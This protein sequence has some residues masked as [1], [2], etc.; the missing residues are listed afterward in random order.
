MA[1]WPQAVYDEYPE[2]P[3]EAKGF[4]IAH[5]KGPI[6]C[7][8]CGETK[9]RAH[10]HRV[11]Y[12][13][14]H[15]SRY[16]NLYTTLC[17]VCKTKQ[18]V[19]KAKE[20]AVER[21]V[22]KATRAE[23][24]KLVKKAAA[25]RATM[26]HVKAA[27][28]KRERNK[29]KARAEDL[30]K[31]ETEAQRELASR[32]LAKVDLL[33]YIERFNPNYLAGWVH[34][35]I[36]RRLRK[37]VEDVENKKSPRLILNVPP[38]HGKSMIASENFP[39]WLLGKHPDWE[40][41]ATSYSLDLP[42]QFSR[43]VRERIRDS[44]YRTLFP[45]TALS[46]DSQAAEMWRTTANGGYR[47]SGVGGGI[48]GM[49]AH[50]VPLTEEVLT[51]EGYKTLGSLIKDGSEAPNVVS[52]ELGQ[53]VERPIDGIITRRSD[54]YYVVTTERGEFK[55]TGEHPVCVGFV[56]GKPQYRRVDDLRV[57]ESLAAFDVPFASGEETGCGVPSLWNTVLKV[58]EQVSWGRERLRNTVSRVLERL[59]GGA[60][61]AAVYRGTD[62]PHL[63]RGVSACQE[64]HKG[65]AG[66]W[67][68]ASLL[69]QQVLRGVS[70]QDLC[71]GAAPPLQ[72]CGDGVLSLRGAVSAQEEPLNCG[73][74]QDPLLQPGVLLQRLG[75]SPYPEGQSYP[76]ATFLPSRVQ[77][78]QGAAAGCQATL[79]RVR[80]DR[81]R[82]TPSGQRQ[83]EQLAGELSPRVPVLPHAASPSSD[84][85]YT[86][87]VACRRVH[88]ELEVGDLC[89]EKAHNYLLRHG[90]LSSNCLIIDDP[91]KDQNEADSETIRQSTW[92]WYTTTAYTRLAPGGGVLVIQ[93]RW[94]DGDLS[95]RI[96][97]AHH[98]F[99]REVDRLTSEIQH[100]KFSGQQAYAKEMIDE[101]AELRASNDTWEIIKYPAIA[102][103]DEVLTQSGHIVPVTS[104]ERRPH[105]RVLRAKGDPLHAD[106]FHL[107]MLKKIKKTLQP[108]HWSALYQQNPIP[109]EGLFFTKD[110]I[111]FEPVIPDYREMYTFAAWDLAVG[112]K[113]MNDYT[114]GIVGALD[115]MDNIHIIDMIRMRSN[116]HYTAEAI[117]DTAQKY[118]CQLNGIEKGVLELALRPQLEKRMRERRFYPPFAEGDLALKPITDKIVRARPLQGRMQ[119]GKV[120]FPAN[121]PWVETVLHELLRF[122][123][124]VHDDIVDA[125]A[126]LARLVMSQAAPKEPRHNRG[127]DSYSN[128]ESWKRR[129]DLIAGA[130][131]KTWMSS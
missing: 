75:W 111:R 94:H 2:Y 17:L 127:Y 123:G 43:K 9:P 25:T 82:A 48:T 108:R 45:K 27:Q 36:C 101:L 120:I 10:M 24:K 56:E 38:R 105:G 61:D 103:H 78:H 125:L 109:D 62:V 59:F 91:V 49:G 89:V 39:S 21:E 117:L 130:G 70:G 7:E 23:R 107:N 65:Q 57:G 11:T 40:I 68:R 74:H 69:L 1:K 64:P 3:D 19:D 88:A 66:P 131:Q 16:K 12:P 15:E 106:R 113:N 84:A 80:R 18:A 28:E 100:A 32:A 98:E 42:L 96:E 60:A 14:G 92:D 77:A 110:M 30:K 46:Q 122:P 4:N 5:P 67:R 31:A 50:C 79:R 93:T 22:V 121:Q 37:F 6:T 124:G 114:V 8:C 112:T 87:V 118:K 13:P 34:E 55:A 52:Y 41:I 33:H 81:D 44:R 104:E 129:L 54:H 83:G 90:L 85:V 63:W 86:R 53:L 119:Q 72:L 115:W 73:P 99:K 71:R 47:A 20:F 97:Q 102:T 76:W 126:W 58:P 35:D 26:Q 51:V 29:A 95:G 128:G 116:T